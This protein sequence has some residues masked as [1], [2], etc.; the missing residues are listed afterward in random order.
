[1]LDAHSDV[2]QK[3]HYQNEDKKRLHDVVEIIINETKGADIEMHCPHANLESNVVWRKGDVRL[4]IENYDEHQ[5]TRFRISSLN[6]LHIKDIR[7]YDA[8]DF[9]C[10]IGPHRHGLFVLNVFSPNMTRF[11]QKHLYPKYHLIIKIWFILCIATIVFILVLKCKRYRR[12]LKALET[13]K[14]M[15][16]VFNENID[17]YI[18]INMRDLVENYKMT[19]GINEPEKIYDY[20]EDEIIEDPVDNAIKMSIKK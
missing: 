13:H 1:M 20:N 5:K 15:N 12:F 11:E 4:R 10:F 6:V 16:N 14:K 2:L 8:G 9:D 3:L 18:E 17:K 19:L 7:E